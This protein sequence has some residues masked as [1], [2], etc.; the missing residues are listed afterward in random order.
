M[1]E[2]NAMKTNTKARP[3]YELLRNNVPTGLMKLSINSWPPGTEPIV[4]HNVLAEYI[5]DTAAKAGVNEVA[6]YNTKVER[7]SKE[8]G[9]WKVQTSTLDAGEI[10]ATTKDWVSIHADNER[11][12]S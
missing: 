12:A 1:V 2:Y 10:E 3:C 9:H 8:Q 6:Q 4:R 11:T 7:V 5:Q